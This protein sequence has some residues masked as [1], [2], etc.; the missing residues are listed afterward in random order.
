MSSY[1]RTS[2]A[3]LL[4]CL[5]FL[6]PV[7]SS[8]QQKPSANADKELTI[9]T[10]TLRNSRGNYV[11]GVP[12]EAFELTDEKE[13][14][15]IEF[16]ENADTPVSIGI[17][18]DTSGSMQLF[19]NREISRPGRIGEAL[20]R[21]LEL[22]NSANEYFLMAFDKTPRFLSDWTSGQA[23]LTQKIG[24][25]PPGRDTAFYDACFA[26]VEKLQ[27]AHYSKRALVLISDG[28]DNLSSHTFNQLRELLKNSDV[29]IYGIGVA[30]PSEVGSSLGMEG[31]GIMM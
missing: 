13:S 5:T 31:M 30:T 12:R 15:P 2:V 1:Y 7:R 10:V 26:A 9:L 17:L 28:Q 11:M 8:G 23:L 16:F 3:V 25:G 19:E 27:T 4:S 29:T 22:S 6:I 24:I 18:V 20:S 14:R 21:F